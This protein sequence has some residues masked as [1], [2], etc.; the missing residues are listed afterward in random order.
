MS[1]LWYVMWEIFAY[2]S[3]TAHPTIS[4]FEK[5]YIERSIGDEKIEVINS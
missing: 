2:E 5:D 1:I 3:P 4:E